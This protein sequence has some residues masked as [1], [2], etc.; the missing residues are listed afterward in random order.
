VALP[1]LHFCDCGNVWQ[2]SSYEKGDVKFKLF[3]VLF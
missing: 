1:A 2:H 3:V